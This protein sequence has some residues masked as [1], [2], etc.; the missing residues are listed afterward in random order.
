MSLHLSILNESINHIMKKTTI[1]L[2]AALVLII[3]ACNTKNQESKDIEKPI[4]ANDYLGQKTPGLIPEP[5]APGLVTTEYWEYGGVFTPDLT[6]FYFLAS[7]GEYEA[8]T[9]VVF[10]YVDGDW[11]K[12]AVSPRV[13]QPTFSP[14]G[15]I[16]HLGRRYMEQTPTGWSEVKT[17]D[18]PF[19]DQL[20]MRL[21]VATN[22]TYYFDTY[23]KDNPEFPIRYSRLINGTYEEPKPL[24]KAINTG[25]QLNHPF[26]A[27]DESYL[28]W[29]AK[30]ED[31]HGNSDIYISFKQKDG[32]W[33]NAINLG[34]KVN[35]DA[36]EAAASVTPDGK[37]LFFNR[38]MG[39][40]DY[41][42]V[43]IFWV[44]AQLIEN[45]RPK[46]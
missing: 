39:S 25:T 19:N 3:S 45:L 6:E 33:G 38:N 31:G 21:S 22:G 17:L 44:D 30:R 8:S 46:S 15:K 37:Y 10:Q 23:D 41:E 36:W 27:P 43:D 24:D 35:T 7:G 28:L 42:N 26:I 14:D 13:G 2:I 11:V 16:M 34:D 9:F 29:D 20:I 18:A 5:F 32:S 4:R 12:S 40:D 1:G